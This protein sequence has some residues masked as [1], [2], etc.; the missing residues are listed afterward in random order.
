MLFKNNFPN[1]N[2]WEMFFARR[3]TRAPVQI[4]HAVA[5]SKFHALSTWQHSFLPNAA[6]SSQSG[7]AYSRSTFFMEVSCDKLPYHRHLIVV[8]RIAVEGS[9]SARAIRNGSTRLSTFSLDISA[10]AR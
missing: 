5:L 10:R 6:S 1:Q 3:A 8:C 4:H 9:G 7:Q 2:R